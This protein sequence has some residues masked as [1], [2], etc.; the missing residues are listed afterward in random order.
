MKNFHLSKTINKITGLFII[1]ILLS[2]D[3]SFAQTK[4]DI[5]NGI[6]ETIESK[7]LNE[8]RIITIKLPDGYGETSQKYPVIYL[9]DGKA[10]FQHVYGAVD[11]LS[12]RRIIPQTIIVSVHNIDRTKDFSPVHDVRL[13]TSGGAENFL[14]FVSEELTKHVDKNYKTSDFS[15]IIGHSFGGTFTTYSLLTKPEVFDAYIAISPYIHFADSYLVKEAKNSL[16][17]KYDNQ[18]FFYVTVGNEPKYYQALAEFSD[19]V[20]K[21]SNK[22]IDYKYVKMEDENHISIPYISVFN[23]LKFIFSDWQINQETFKQGLAA[24]DK[25]YKLVSNKYGLELE[26]PENIINTLGYNHLQHNDIDNAIEIFIENVKRYPLSPNVYDSLGEAYENNKQ[27]KLAQ[28]N[29]QKAYDLASKQNNINT[30]V[31]LKNLNRVHE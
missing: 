3:S 31:Y 11:F 17:S 27:L 30:P 14:N 6:E 26:T 24:I 19:L 13:P 9:L 15:V 8:K 18:K 4:N 29:Y 7:I 25:H 16:K 21:K 10:N 23:G 12:R 20:N 28:E 5:V 22:T 2:V 1:L